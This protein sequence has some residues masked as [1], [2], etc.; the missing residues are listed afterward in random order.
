LQQCV[1]TCKHHSTNQA[2]TKHERYLPGEGVGVTRPCNFWIQLSPRELDAVSPLTKDYS[3]FVNLS[4]VPS[5]PELCY[6][7]LNTS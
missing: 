3:P 4:A 5:M 7:V 2:Q 1:C 6:G